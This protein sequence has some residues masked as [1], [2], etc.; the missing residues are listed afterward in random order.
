VARFLRAAGTC[1]RV[2]V[3]GEPAMTRPG[4]DR[5]QDRQSVGAGGLTLRMA[6]KFSP[7]GRDVG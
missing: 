4:F 5:S 6:I 2:P 3:P 1:G 7:Y